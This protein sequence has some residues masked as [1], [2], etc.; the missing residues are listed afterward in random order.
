VIVTI[1]VSALVLVVVA[2]AVFVLIRYLPIVANLFMNVTVRPEPAEG[3]RLDGEDVAF[4][5]AD[6]VLLAG[7]LTRAPREGPSA[8]GSPSATGGVGGSPVI[9]FCH[10]FGA[11]RHSAVKNAA[12]L[13]DAGFRVF[14]FDFRGHGDSEQP[15]GYSPRHWVT[16]YEVRDLR[17]ALAYLKDRRD[18]AG[19]RVGLFGMSRGAST[20]IVVAA[21]DPFVAGIVSDGAF[22]TGH[23]LHSYMRR[24]GPIFVDPYLLLLS[25][26]DSVLSVFRWLATKL[27][28]HRMAVRCVSVVRALRR[29]KTPILFVH[30]EKDSY[31]EMDQAKLL[32]EL[33][34][35]SK[36][37]WVVPEAD[38]N[39]AV[40]VAPTEYSRRVVHF[41]RAVLGV[42]EPTV[43]GSPNAMSR[44][45]G[46][47]VS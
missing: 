3:G 33:A 15:V 31:I 12:C 18:T 27:A 36:E 2:E 30:G 24:W 40:D 42:T 34:G 29:L 37:L 11:D 22:S 38:H 1:V 47:P 13:R 23:T 19:A 45:G 7:T 10:E 5:T 20:A 25:R 39:Q 41:F 44:V 9:V 8:L 4:A 6:G 46:P 28:E 26:P 17:A 43:T 21:D 32:F 16:E 14:A 35:G